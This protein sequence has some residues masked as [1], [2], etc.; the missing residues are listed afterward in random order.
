MLNVTVIG[1]LL[2]LG[3]VPVKLSHNADEKY[4]S[5][6]VSESFFLFLKSTFEHMKSK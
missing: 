4:K 2:G 5:L 1:E 3:C 6:N